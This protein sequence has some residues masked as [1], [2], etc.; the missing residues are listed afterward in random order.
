MQITG[1]MGDQ[2][3]TLAAQN[4]NDTLSGLEP[5]KDSSE[6]HSGTWPNQNDEETGLT[7]VV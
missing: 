1:G 6:V 4:S 2:L 7:E 3:F 5:R